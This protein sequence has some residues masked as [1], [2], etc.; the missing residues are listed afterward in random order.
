MVKLHEKPLRML[1]GLPALPLLLLALLVRLFLLFFQ[2]GDPLRCLEQNLVGLLLEKSLLVSAFLELLVKRAHQLLLQAI[3]LFELGNANFLDHLPNGSCSSSLLSHCLLLLP[4]H[5]GAPLLLLLPLPLLLL[6]PPGLLLLL[7]PCLNHH[8]PARVLHAFPVSLFF[9]PPRLSTEVDLHAQAQAPGHAQASS[10]SKAPSDTQAPR[11]AQAPG[12]APGQ[13][14]AGHGA[15]GRRH[16]R[17]D[18]RQ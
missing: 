13:A 3:K 16:R 1:L 10:H 4:H 5:L 9:P 14:Q 6:P 15:L 17:H 12:Q 18:S 8:H 2:Y 11:H 7:S